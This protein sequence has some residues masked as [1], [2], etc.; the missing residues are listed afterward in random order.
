MFQIGSTPKLDSGYRF[1]LQQVG[2]LTDFPDFGPGSLGAFITLRQG[3]T[4][5]VLGLT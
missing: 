2:E 5:M 3:L 1:C 4:L